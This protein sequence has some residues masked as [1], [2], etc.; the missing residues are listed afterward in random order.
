MP[1]DR[2]EQAI[3]AEVVMGQRV[4]PEELDGLGRR[5]QPSLDGTSRMNREVGSGRHAASLGR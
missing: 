4:T 3:R 5:R 2:R 1:V